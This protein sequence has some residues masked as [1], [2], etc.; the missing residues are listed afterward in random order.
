MCAVCEFW[1]KVRPR[2]FWCVAM[3]SVVLFIFRL[4]YY[5]IKRLDV[6]SLEDIPHSFFLLMA[7]DRPSIICVSCTM[8]SIECNNSNILL[9]IYFQI[10]IKNKI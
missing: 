3:R 8:T 10:I 5:Y 2:T 9:K 7:V 1:V 4:F 6:T